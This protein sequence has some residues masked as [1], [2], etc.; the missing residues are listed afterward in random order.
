MSQLMQLNA[1]VFHKH[2]VTE[3]IFPSSSFS[4]RSCYVCTS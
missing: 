2:I 4:S 3:D 1:K